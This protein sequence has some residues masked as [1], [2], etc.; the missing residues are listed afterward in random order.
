MALNPDDLLLIGRATQN[1]TTEYSNLKFDILSNVDSNATVYVGETEPTPLYEGL[2]WWKPSESTLFIYETPLTDG[3]VTGLNLINGGRF[4][5]VNEEQF[6]SGGS[7]H[8]LKIKVTGTNGINGTITSYDIVNDGHGYKVND[9]VT[10]NS[11]FGTPAT[12]VIT[13]VT[14]VPG[15]QW[16]AV[17][18]GDI[19]GGNASGV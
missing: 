4:Y 5:S 3:V 2:L 17:G 10:M 7:G 8:E 14:S 11:D 6:A 13:S 9:S 18:G 12:F 19:D 16:V 1:F 15:A